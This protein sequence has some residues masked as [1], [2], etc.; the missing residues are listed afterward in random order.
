[1]VYIKW[2]ILLKLSRKGVFMQIIHYVI[3]DENGIH[4]RPAGLF[5]KAA[6]GFVSDVKIT[7]GEKDA[8]GKRLFGVMGLGVKK[9]DK[10]SVTV[11]GDDEEK[12]VKELESF[13][14]ANL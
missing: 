13:L 6:S 8:D 7:K 4:A 9:G 14:K 5:V 1:M 2:F 12:A 11:A 3:T 10:I